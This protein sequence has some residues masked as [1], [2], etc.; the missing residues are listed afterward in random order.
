MT[1][2]TVLATLGWPRSVAAA[3][4]QPVRRVTTG[5]LLI[6]LREQHHAEGIGWFDQ[7]RLELDPRQFQQLQAVLGLKSDALDAAVAGSSRDACHSRARRPRCRGVRRRAATAAR[8]PA[9]RR[10]ASCS[11]RKLA[12]CNGARSSDRIDRVNRLSAGSV[13][14]VA[15]DRQLALLEQLFEVVDAFLL[16]GADV[17]QNDA[18]AH[19]FLAA[20]LERLGV[21]LDLK[22]FD[23]ERVFEHLV[24]SR[25]TA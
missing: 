11:R 18:Q 8:P 9:H 13:L 21:E 16:F 24:S 17:F 20:E 15:G 22:A 7:R 2:R 3:A 25:S 10:P 23:F 4:G 12:R 5:G 19:F 1:G 14:L 6:D